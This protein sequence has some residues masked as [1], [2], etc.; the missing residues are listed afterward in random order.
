MAAVALSTGYSGAAQQSGTSPS[1]YPS[2]SVAVPPRPPCRHGVLGKAKPRL[3][4]LNPI[5]MASS[6]LSLCS[7]TRSLFS[8]LHLLPVPSA[9]C[10]AIVAAASWTFRRRSD[11]LV[12]LLLVHPFSCDSFFLPPSRF[13]PGKHPWPL[14]F[15][16]AFPHTRA[17]PPFDPFVFPYGDSLAHHT[18]PLLYLRYPVRTISSFVCLQLLLRV[19]SHGVF[20]SP[21]SWSICHF[22]PRSPLCASAS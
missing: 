20:Y 18:T 17:A 2:L 10:E 3:H 6:S 11:P 15:S 5:T 19:P 4:S 9:H 16:C 1:H 13:P 12:P 21:P 14:F 7:H 22:R 8:R